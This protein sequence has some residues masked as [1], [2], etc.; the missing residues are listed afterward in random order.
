MKIPFIANSLRMIRK[1]E[2]TLLKNESGQVLFFFAVIAMV[3]VIFAGTITD[4]GMTITKKIKTQ[5]AA[6]AAAL[7]AGGWVA[8]MGNLEFTMNGIHWDMNYTLA[9][10]ITIS[11][12]IAMIICIICLALSWL[13]FGIGQVF[14]SVYNTTKSIESSIL[15]ACCKVHKITDKIIEPVQSCLVKATPFLALF[16]ANF[17]ARNNG[18]SSLPELF[19]DALPFS[20]DAKDAVNNAMDKI[21]DL[22][23]PLPIY[24]W[25]LSPNLKIW[26]NLGVNEIFKFPDGLKSI[27]QNASKPE[28]A[29]PYRIGPAMPFT[30][31]LPFWFEKYDDL[32]WNDGFVVQ[33]DKKSEW[34]ET[35]G[36]FDGITDFNIDLGLDFNIDLTP[37]WWKDLKAKI[38]AFID[39]IENAITDWLKDTYAFLFGWIPDLPCLGDDENGNPVPNPE[40]MPEPPPD[41]PSGV[42][43]IAHFTFVVGMKSELGTFLKFFGTTIGEDPAKSNI[44]MTWAFATVKVRG[45]ALHPAGLVKSGS[46]FEQIKMH[47]VP[48]WISAEPFFTQ[49]RF[50]T[51]YE[52]DWEAALSPVAFQIW[53]SKKFWT[54]KVKKTILQGKLLGIN[55]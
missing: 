19:M 47:I 10:I 46:S 50:V 9:Q 26:D 15:T 55:H 53:Q 45:H 42:E 22:P 36:L 51:G 37:Q 32:N 34:Y 23:L 40:T 8:R 27:V 12:D 21:K 28:Y 30:G 4:Y 18:A 13:P 44:P 20:Q 14:Y 3:L 35:W 41:Q 43:D 54:K 24:T 33:K 31:T 48:F 52:G 1:R 2:Q 11:S 7:A 25:T 29:N 6:D 39:G 5:T 16:H 17:A 49:K 38:E